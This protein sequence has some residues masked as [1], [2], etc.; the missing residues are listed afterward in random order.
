MKK[1]LVMFI[2]ILTMWVSLGYY[3]DTWY[4]VA[5][6]TSPYYESN[7]DYSNEVN[8]EYRIKSAQLFNTIRNNFPINISN[9]D[10]INRRKNYQWTITQII[11]N[12]QNKELIWIV[13]HLESRIQ[14]RVDKLSKT[15]N[16]GCNTTY[17][18]SC[19]LWWEYNNCIQQCR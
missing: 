1:L 12:S 6:W 4:W 19:L 11:Q 5:D 3:T 2:C 7:S 13:K 16:V 8:T 18:L 14:Q 15:A 17:M 10:R 9:S